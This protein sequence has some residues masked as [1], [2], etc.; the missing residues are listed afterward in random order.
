[1]SAH[2]ILLAIVSDHRKG[3]NTKI[4]DLCDIL[5]ISR[6]ECIDL[7]QLVGSQVSEIGFTLL[8]GCNSRMDSQGKAIPQ[9]ATTTHYTHLADGFKKC[10]FVYLIKTYGSTEEDITNI[11][12]HVPEIVYVYTVLYLNGNELEYERVVSSLLQI[13]RTEDTLKHAINRRY[14]Y[15][16]KR[17]HKYFVRPGWKFYLE[18]PK[19]SSEEY[20]ASLKASCI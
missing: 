12:E 16:K 8:P 3:R 17:N 15:K 9:E 18:F 2:S 13:N 19:F 14:F 20:I 5:Q 7:L 1:M 4:S 10:D 6:K 11:T